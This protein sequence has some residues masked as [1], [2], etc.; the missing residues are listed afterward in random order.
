MLTLIFPVTILLLGYVVTGFVLIE[1][2]LWI[3]RKLDSITPHRPVMPPAKDFEVFSPKI[4][5]A[6]A[7]PPALPAAFSG[8]PIFPDPEQPP[9]SRKSPWSELEQ[10]ASWGSAHV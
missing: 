1:I 3:M 9:G 4:V 6:Y 8:A 5:D 2:T 7:G 10:H